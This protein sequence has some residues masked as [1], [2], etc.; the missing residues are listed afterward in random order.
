MNNLT[1]DYMAIDTNVFEHL[2]NPEKNTN[3]HIQKLLTSLKERDICL[4][5]DEGKRIEGEYENRI[6]P[7]LRNTSDTNH[8]RL[9]LEFWFVRKINHR[10]RVPVDAMDELMKGIKQIIIEKDRNC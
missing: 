1:N 7:K 6:G 2:L 5:V 10:K 4:I 3:N 8:I 9:L